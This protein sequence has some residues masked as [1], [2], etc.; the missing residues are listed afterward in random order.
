MNKLKCIVTSVSSSDMLTKID[1]LC[2]DVAL[3]AFAIEMDLDSICRGDEIVVLFKE[4]EVSIA[5]NFIGEISL[6]NRF[7]CKVEDIEKGDLLAQLRLSFFNHYI[8][9][10]ISMKSVKNMDLQVGDN[11]TAFVKSTE[12]IVTDIDDE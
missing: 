3:T 11:V 10:I 7:T 8:D 9:S 6:Q 5:K 12:M 2:D 1:M 4:S